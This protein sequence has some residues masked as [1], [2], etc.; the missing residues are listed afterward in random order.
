MTLLTPFLMRSD[1]LL[2]AYAVLGALLIRANARTPLAVRVTRFVALKRPPSA[3]AT[4]VFLALL[5]RRT[6]VSLAFPIADAL[7]VLAYAFT[8]LADRATRAVAFKRGP[9]A[10]AAGVFR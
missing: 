5:G 10:R 1:H 4:S 8:P 3:S 7:T 2:R 9:F 6:R